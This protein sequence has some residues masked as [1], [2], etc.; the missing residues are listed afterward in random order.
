MTHFWPPTHNLLYPKLEL[1]SLNF[2]PQ[3]PKYP[4]SPDLHGGVVVQSVNSNNL[5]YQHHCVLNTV[6]H[7]GARTV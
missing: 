2:L 6:P 5:G 3:G 7:A 4:S 1:S